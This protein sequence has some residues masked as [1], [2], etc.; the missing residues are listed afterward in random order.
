M[1][2]QLTDP[3]IRNLR[4]T[5]KQ[6]LVWDTVV[7]GFGIRVSPGGSKTFNQ[8]YRSNGKLRR[9]SLAS[10]PDHGV[11]DARKLAR[12]IKKEA[13]LGN[14]PQRKKRDER[15]Q[16]GVR[17]FPAL[18]GQYIRHSMTETRSWHEA[19][20]VLTRREI[21]EPWRHLA[22]GSITR[23]DVSEV[24]DAV[25]LRGPSAETHAHADLRRF[26]NWCKRRG[27]IEL[28]PC[29]GIEIR[30]KAKPRTRVLSLDELRRV[31]GAAKSLGTP[32]GCF[33]MI[34]ILTLQRRGD[35]AN[36]RDVD[37]DLSEGTWTQPTNKS[38]REHKVFLCDLAVDLLAELTRGSTGYVFQARGSLRPVSG[39]S[40][41]KRQLDNQSLV[42][43]WCLHDLRRTAT[44]HM[45]MLGVPIHVCELI[46]NHRTRALDGIAGVYNRNTFEREQRSA[47]QRWGEFI[48]TEVDANSTALLTL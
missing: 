28:N 27:F 6:Y 24:L 37:L 41:W 30:S 20:R 21:N 33:V 31:W 35:V 32:F 23:T 5:E 4:P 38:D 48:K 22:I 25:R 18:V 17:L 16:Y 34:L 39:F 26:F 43:N 1:K 46:L 13:M 14:D 12:A 9:M 36:V 11:A 3:F 7:T 42:E 29:D 2:R 45:S 10:F 47:M 19:K 15:L 40:K 44:T 8:L